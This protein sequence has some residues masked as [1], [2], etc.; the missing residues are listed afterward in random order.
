MKFFHRMAALLLAGV[1]ALGLAACGGIT[2]DDAEAYIQGLLD[3]SYLG[4]YNQE[5]LDLADI[6]EEES[7]TEDYEWNTAAEAEILREYL[8]IQSTDAAVQQSVDLVKEIYSHSRYSVT[9][10]SK[11]EDG[12]YAVTVSIQPMDILIRYQNQTDVNEIWMTVLAEHGVMDQ[13]TLDA[14]S[15]EEY[16]A[17]EDIYAAAVLDGIQALVPEMGYGPEQSVVLQLQL[18]GDTYTLVDTDWQHLDGMIIDYTGQ[19][20]DPTLVGQDMGEA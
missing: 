1:M 16:M 6:T 18:E 13:A 12:S 7:R 19:Y 10:A 5:Y 3:A 17:L 20:C 8:A 15:D 9:G 4:Q 11:L 2:S 14:M